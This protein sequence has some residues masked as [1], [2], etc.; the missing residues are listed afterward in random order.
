MKQPPASPEPIEWESVG[1]QPGQ[2]MQA[3][4][5]D[6]Q[7]DVKQLDGGL[8]AYRFRQGPAIW[9]RGRCRSTMRY[10]MDQAENWLRGK[11]VSIPIE[12]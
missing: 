4:L 3:R 11:P 6:Y 9:L 12:T 8:I 2:H 10:M 1:T 5:G 7:V